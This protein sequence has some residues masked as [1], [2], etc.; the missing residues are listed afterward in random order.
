MEIS[1]ADF[2]ANPTVVIGLLVVFIGLNLLIVTKDISKGIEKASK[3]LMPVL[4]VL[5]LVVIL[6]SVTL[7]ELWK[8]SNIT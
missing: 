5:V 4:F 2:Q 6:R 7:M 8:E 1:F 3:I